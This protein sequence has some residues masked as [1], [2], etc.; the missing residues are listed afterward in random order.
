[1]RTY[2]AL[3]SFL[4]LLSWS[5]AAKAS[6]PSGLIAGLAFLSVAIPFL[7]GSIFVTARAWAKRKYSDRFYTVNQIVVSSIFLFVGVLA[8]VAALYAEKGSLHVEE[9]LIMAAV[10]IGPPAIFVIVPWTLHLFQRRD[11]A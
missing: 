11:V 7:L 8:F 4:S 2:F 6:D 5:P 3:L 1:M 9:V 10:L